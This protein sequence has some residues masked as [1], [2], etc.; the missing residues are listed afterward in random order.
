[1]VSF[2]L[3]MKTVNRYIYTVL[4]LRSVKA[5]A[6]PANNAAYFED[7]INEDSLMDKWKVCE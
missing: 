2:S 7:N 6:I 4:M 5:A 3:Y 1:M